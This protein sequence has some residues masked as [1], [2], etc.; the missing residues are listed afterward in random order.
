MDKLKIKLSRE[1][2]LKLSGLC[3][4][5]HISPDDLLSALVMSINVEKLEASVEDH[6][7]KS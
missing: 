4:S 5:Y 6:K 3:L 2:S 7:K 1:A